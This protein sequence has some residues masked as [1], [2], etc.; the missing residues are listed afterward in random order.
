MAKCEKQGEAIARIDF[1]R[2]RLGVAKPA[3]RDQ[4]VKEG[5][6]SLFANVR[7]GSKWESESNRPSPTIHLSE[8]AP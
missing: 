7:S 3:L 4:I 8:L 1:E 5:V 2:A 6:E